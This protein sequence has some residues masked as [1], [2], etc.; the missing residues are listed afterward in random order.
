MTLILAKVKE[1]SQ[2][3][4]C[5]EYLLHVWLPISVDILLSRFDNRLW[6][7]S[8]LRGHEEAVEEATPSNAE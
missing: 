4:I 2:G 7:D 3:V 6:L 8:Q 5:L 1:A